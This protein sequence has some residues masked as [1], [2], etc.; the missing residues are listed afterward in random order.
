MTFARK[1]QQM[2]SLMALGLCIHAPL[3]PAF[4]N[5]SLPTS[6][7]P[8]RR[9]CLRGSFKDFLRRETLQRGPYRPYGGVR[10]FSDN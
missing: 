6:V 3:S 2:V 7:D 9:L 4:F 5:P 1:Y 10:G 8:I